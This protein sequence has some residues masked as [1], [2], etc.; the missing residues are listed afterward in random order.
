MIARGKIRAQRNPYIGQSLST[1]R[2]RIES[3]ALLFEREAAGAC[4]PK[5]YH[6][7]REKC[8]LVMEDLFDYENLRHAL[9]N[10]KYFSGFAGDIT[11]FLVHTLLL[12]TD[13]VMD[14]M[15]KKEKVRE[16]INPPLCRISERLVF[17]EPYDEEENHNIL[18]REN[19]AFYIRE[20]YHDKRLHLEVAKLKNIFQ[21]KAQ[22]LLHGDLHTGSIFAKEGATRILDPEF[23]FYGPDGP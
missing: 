23:A 6:Y 16:F 10:R 20:L 8:F 19:E 13:L 17:S 12:S 22:S 21:T 11:S 4:V 7:D 5:V 15:K 1:D 14:P 9:M 3:S 18:D 2:S